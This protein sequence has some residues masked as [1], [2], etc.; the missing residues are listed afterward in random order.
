MTSTCFPYAGW[1]MTN[2][3]WQMTNGG[4]GMT[5]AATK[6]ATHVS[7]E[8]ESGWPLPLPFHRG[9]LLGLE[10]RAKRLG[11]ALGLE[12]G[13]PFGRGLPGLGIAA[14]QGLEQPPGAIRQFLQD[15]LSQGAVDLRRAQRVLPEPGRA[16]RRG[17][18]L[19]QEQ[20]HVHRN[21]VGVVD[22]RVP[23]GS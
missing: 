22:Q 14:R 8:P 2:A 4:W 15:L 23:C 21:L 9:R 7:R 3:G 19:D 11:R 20:E 16:C 18:N 6:R 17:Q 12:P 13:D 10:C 1:Q 5:N